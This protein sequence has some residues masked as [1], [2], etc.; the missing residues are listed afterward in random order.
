MYQVV[1]HLYF[2]VGSYLTAALLTKLRTFLTQC[3]WKS[4]WLKCQAA[5]IYLINCKMTHPGK[6]HSTWLRTWWRQFKVTLW[7]CDRWSLFLSCPKQHLWC[8]RLPEESL[9]KTSTPCSSLPG[10]LLRVMGGA[11]CWKRTGRRP[12]PWRWRGEPGLPRCHQDQDQPLQT[13]CQ[14]IFNYLNFCLTVNFHS[15][16]S[17]LEP[18]LYK[19]NIIKASHKKSLY[20][21]LHKTE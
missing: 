18:K 10:W 6:Q 3:R 5:P 15:G 2:Q 19:K 20:I 4:T 16:P 13:E 8:D 21:V 1:L 12:R 7:Q 14:C 11:A 9:L 17:R